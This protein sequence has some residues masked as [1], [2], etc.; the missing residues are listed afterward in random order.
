MVATATSSAT[1]VLGGVRFPAAGT[2]ARRSPSPPLL[3]SPRRSFS[4]IALHLSDVQRF[5]SL[6]VKATSSEETSS[7]IETEELL[8]DLKQKWDS[9]ENKSSVFMYGGGAIVALWLS[10]ALI[11]A[12][13]S[14]PL[15]PKLLELVGVGYTGWFV[16]RY[17]LFKSSRKELAEDIESLKKRI[18]GTE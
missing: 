12:I 5:S 18:A 11:G 6:K 15:L 14:I 4:R 1:T 10:S 3:P 7:S 2:L 8:A 9:I 13:N 16:Y 17:L